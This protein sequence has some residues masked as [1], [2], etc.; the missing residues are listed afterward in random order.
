MASNT[1][2]LQNNDALKQLP[3]KMKKSIEEK[4]ST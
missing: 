1:E 3:K 2:I 4:S